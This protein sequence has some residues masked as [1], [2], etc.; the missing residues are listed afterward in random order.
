[1]VW[2]IIMTVLITTADVNFAKKIKDIC[3]VSKVRFL[4][5]IFFW[6]SQYFTK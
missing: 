4:I 2:C 5:K 1:M 3:V 6:N